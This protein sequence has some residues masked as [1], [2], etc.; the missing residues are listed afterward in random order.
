MNR[1]V[2]VTWPLALLIVS[3]LA[4]Q[5]AARAAFTGHRALSQA[6]ASL[7]CEAPPNDDVRVLER[8]LTLIKERG[9]A[10]ST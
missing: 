2:S 6:A 3:G 5:G 4:F 7:E 9:K 8:C 10:T 1:I